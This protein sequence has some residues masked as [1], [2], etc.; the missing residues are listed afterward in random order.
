VA[1]PA[2]VRPARRQWRRRRRIALF[3][4]CPAQAG[5]DVAIEPPLPQPLLAVM[6]NGA[7]TEFFTDKSVTIRE[8]TAEVLLEY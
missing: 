4:S 6:V 1:G 3:V 7:A 2:T 8:F 5:R